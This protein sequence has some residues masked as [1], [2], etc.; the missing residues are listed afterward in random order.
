[1]FCPIYLNTWNVQ[2]PISPSSAQ[3]KVLSGP[4]QDVARAILTADVWRGRRRLKSKETQAADDKAVQYILGADDKTAQ[5][6]LGKVEQDKKTK[7]KTENDPE[8]LN[9]SEKAAQKE[10]VA[11]AQDIDDPAR[12]LNMN[13]VD[14]CDSENEDNIPRDM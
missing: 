14:D 10:D 4:S 5:G 1:M 8:K 7:L 6:M 12:Q 11:V 13:A 3:E 2:I 9:G